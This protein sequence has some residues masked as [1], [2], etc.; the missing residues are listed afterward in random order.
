MLISRFTCKKIMKNFEMVILFVIAEGL[1]KQES[2][3]STVSAGGPCWT[4][5]AEVPLLR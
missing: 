4:G 1:S 2:K 5:K 3:P